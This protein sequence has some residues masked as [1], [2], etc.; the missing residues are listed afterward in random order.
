MRD[1][2]AIQSKK[3]PENDPVQIRRLVQNGECN[4]AIKRPANPAGPG[5]ILS[6]ALR[7]PKGLPTALE[8]AH[9][10]FV[11]GVKER[12]SAQTGLVR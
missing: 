3:T 2:A 5:S 10:R 4:Q 9:R 7:L 6:S 1:Q 12:S 8:D 11:E